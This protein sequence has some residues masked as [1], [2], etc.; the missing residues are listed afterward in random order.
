MTQIL[1]VNASNLLINRKASGRY[2]HQMMPRSPDA[3]I[4]TELDTHFGGWPL[5]FYDFSGKTKNW[6]FEFRVYYNIP[7]DENVQN[8]P[9]ILESCLIN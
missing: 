6:S 1:V 7:L 8:T 4:S 9:A 5:K 2:G 3:N